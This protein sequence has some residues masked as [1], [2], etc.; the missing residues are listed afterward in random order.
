MSGPKKPSDADMNLDL[1]EFERRID[2]QNSWDGTCFQAV[3]C[4]LEYAEHRC[5]ELEKWLRWI[6]HDVQDLSLIGNHKYKLSK[7]SIERIYLY[8]KG[9][10]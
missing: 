10:A 1:E 3:R 5:R 6:R 9:E 2:K 8:A 4:R 7:E